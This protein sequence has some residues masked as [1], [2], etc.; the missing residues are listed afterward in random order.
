M[1]C[2]IKRFKWGNEGICEMKSTCREKWLLRGRSGGWILGDP[3]L[4]TIRSVFRGSQCGCPNKGTF[5]SGV[6]VA[7]RGRV[8]WRWWKAERRRRR[9]VRLL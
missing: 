5:R 8:L 6:G 1:D 3:N 2:K 9:G 4:H 7:E